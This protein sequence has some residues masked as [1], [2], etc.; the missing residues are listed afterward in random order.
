LSDNG[1]LRDAFLSVLQGSVIT[2]QQGAA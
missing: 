1:D 2:Q